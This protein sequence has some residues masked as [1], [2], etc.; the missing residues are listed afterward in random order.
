[1]T[2][3]VSFRASD[4]LDAFLEAL[5]EERMTTKST[6]AQML[7]AERA[8]QIKAERDEESNTG[9][10]RVEPPTDPPS[11]APGAGDAEPDREPDPESDSAVVGDDGPNADPDLEEEELEVDPVPEADPGLEDEEE[12]DP[13]LQGEDEVGDAEEGPEAEIFEQYPEK[14]YV[15]NSDTGNQYAV[16]TAT[17]DVKYYKTERH[18]ANRLHQEYES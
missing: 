17:G 16:E 2:K 4:E 12:G 14:W 8:R 11:S 1:M 3:T 5:A 18:A 13:T 10:P 6:V 7:V 9:D 15:P